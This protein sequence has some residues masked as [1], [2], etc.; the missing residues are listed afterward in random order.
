LFN[1]SVGS[2]ELLAPVFRPMAAA[3]AAAAAAKV[4]SKTMGLVWHWLAKTAEPGD[5]KRRDS[6]L[7]TMKMKMTNKSIKDRL[8]TRDHDDD[9]TAATSSTIWSHSQTKHTQRSD[10]LS[11]GLQ[12][13]LLFKSKHAGDAHARA[14]QR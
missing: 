7:D 10:S 11:S 6:R 14:G 2:S 4:R 12:P 8:G 13:G 3:A 9:G 1:L 5:W